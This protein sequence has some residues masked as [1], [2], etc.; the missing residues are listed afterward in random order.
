MLL[1]TISQF[2]S[3]RQNFF[4]KIFKPIWKLDSG[5]STFAAA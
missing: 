4:Q 1:S 5:G 3:P 2:S